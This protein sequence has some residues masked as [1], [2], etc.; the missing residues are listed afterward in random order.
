MTFI[1]IQLLN[2]C[3]TANLL[4]LAVLALRKLL[5]KMPQFLICIL[6]GF[7]AI[8]LTC[9]ILIETV[10]SINSE[11]NIITPFVDTSN[12][13]IQSN[14][15]GA[16]TSFAPDHIITEEKVKFLSAIWLLGVFVLLLYAAINCIKLKKQIS[17]AI[18][19]YSNIWICD[20]IETSFVFGILRPK[21]YL[22]S[23]TESC[24]W[25]YILAHEQAHLKRYD[26]WWK[27]LGFLIF[28]LY[29][30]NPLI[31]AAYIFLC[32]DIEIA[33][34]ERATRHFNLEDKKIYS[35]LLLSCSC[36]QKMLMSYPL[37]FGAADIKERIKRVLYYKKPALWT[38]FVVLPVYIIIVL[39]FL[40]NPIKQINPIDIQ[41]TDSKPDKY[42]VE[43]V[44]NKWKTVYKD[45]YEYLDY[46]FVLY[47]HTVSNGVVEEVF[48][49]DITYH[50]KNTNINKTEHYIADMKAAYTKTQP[51]DITLW[52]DNSGGEMKSL[53]LF[54]EIL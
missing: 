8:R 28:A 7:V 51:S 34:D 42:V 54:G 33:C 43:Y 23:N 16:V 39:C 13:T 26:H 53:S 35:K 10:L 15:T 45:Y 52:I 17:T 5:K 50:P 21:I 41:Q 6:W 40:T 9:P 18:P 1:F 30:F 47:S 27:P 4:I 44:I 19:L 32:R 48:M 24:Y 36:S 12:I 3:I 49:A 29:W 11:T 25:H 38:I 14:V 46:S 2:R 22:P 31:W 20:D 37:S